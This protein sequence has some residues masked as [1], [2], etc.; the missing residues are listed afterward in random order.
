MWKQAEAVAADHHF[1][2][3]QLPFNLLE[4]GGSATAEFAHSKNL[5]VLINRPLN[6]MHRN[7][8]IRL[9]DLFP[10]AYPATVEEVSTTVDSLIVAEKEL[11]HRWLPQLEI[12]EETHQQLQ[13]Y[14]AIGH[15]LSGQW[16]SFHTFHNWRD[17]Q[18]QF[19]MPR[20]QAAI[21]FLANAENLPEGLFSWLQRYVET[22]ND[23]S[24]VIGAFDQESGSRQAQFIHNT[25]VLA[26]ADWQADTLSQT[27]V[28]ALRSTEGITS[29]L[30]GMRH[31]HYVDDMIAELQRPV[32]IKNR[33][34][35]WDEIR[36]RLQGLDQ[37]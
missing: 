12:D 4:N 27:A 24:T 13:A 31:P 28:R 23:A 15:I 36:L 6:A 1:R 34:L 33:H 14:L 22:V 2:I 37:Q 20:A 5:G 10:P 32:A 29:V 35:S 19:L 7:R 8:L 21:A 18:S 16:N 17:V 25:A 11:S 3:V 9:V 30:V 26:D